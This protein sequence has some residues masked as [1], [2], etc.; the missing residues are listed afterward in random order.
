MPPVCFY[1]ILR[2]VPKPIRDEAR[3]IGV[4]VLCPVLGVSLFR[5]NLASTGL[6][7]RSERYQALDLLGRGYEHFIPRG[8]W[9]GQDLHKMHEECTNIIQ[10]S[11][12]GSAL[13]DPYTLLEFLMKERVLPC[14]S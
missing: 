2:Y 12:P 5:Y 1:T 7:P 4:I 9:L 11:K 13:G 3:N 10:F 8:S 14:A 6:N